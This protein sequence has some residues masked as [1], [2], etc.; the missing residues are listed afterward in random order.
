[1]YSDPEDTTLLD[2]ENPEGNQGRLVK[3]AQ[4]TPLSDDEPLGFS[5]DE[6]Q[7]IRAFLMEEGPKQSDQDRL[8]ALVDSLKDP[9]E[10]KSKQLK[11]EL[12]E[13]F[14]TTMRRL[15][16]TQ[17]FLDVE[18][19][20]NTAKGI[21]VFNS[22]CKEMD[23]ATLA[24]YEVLTE[25]YETT[26]DEITNLMEKLKAEYSHRD[27]LWVAL[28]QKLDEIAGPVLEELQD[29]PGAVEQRISR[30]EKGYEA[31]QKEGKQAPAISEKRIQELLLQLGDSSL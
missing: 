18:V 16:K 3:E 13:A 25:A 21:A 22:A 8:D 9:F 26:R 1:M 20:T 14:I 31:M 2:A 5:L 17:Q 23:T 12:T 6:E 28:E 10:R 27:Q 15:K 29:L 11:E 24:E 4:E 19:D 7:S 30:L